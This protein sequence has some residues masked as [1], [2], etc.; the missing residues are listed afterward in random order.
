MRRGETDCGVGGLPAHLEILAIGPRED[1][2]RLFHQQ[3]AL[4]ENNAVEVL[5]VDLDEPAVER[6][7]EPGDHVQQRALSAARAAEQQHFRASGHL[8]VAIREHD[9][10]LV[11][12]IQVRAADR[13][14]WHLL[15]LCSLR[16]GPK[17]GVLLLLPLLGFLLSLLLLVN[18][19]RVGGVTLE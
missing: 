10:V 18:R 1:H 16:C 2:R 11:L 8:Q 4:V 13:R 19:A 12:E 6:L 14:S 5:A 17:L 15:C 7:V 9:L 3:E